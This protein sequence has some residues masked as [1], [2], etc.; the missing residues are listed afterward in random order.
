MSFIK[1]IILCVI[2]FCAISIP[3]V[4]AQT[5][6]SFHHLTRNEGLLHDNVTCM[7]QDEI[8]YIWIGTHRGINR[9]D[10]YAMDSYQ[11]K[12]NKSM[13]V[14]AN[15]VYD[16]LNMGKYLWLATQEG[17]F[18]FNIHTKQYTSFK[19]ADSALSDFFKGVRHLKRAP[20]NNCFW[21]ISNQQVR[22]VKITT[23]SE[24]NT[25]PLLTSVRIGSS[26]GLVSNNGTPNVVDNGKD[27]GWL[28]ANNT[29]STYIIHPNHQLDILNNVPQISCIGLRDMAY[30]KGYL[31]LAYPEKL[32]KYKVGKLGKLTLLKEKIFKTHGGFIR[33]KPAGKYIWLAAND[34]LIRINKDNLDRFQSYKHA[35]NVDNSV[36]NDINNIYID[37]NDNIWVSGWMAGIAYAHT[38]QPFFHTLKYD[39]FNTSGAVGGNAEFISALHYD[40]DGYVYI[41]RKFGGISRL[42]TKTKQIEWDYSINAAL[43]NSITFIET[44]NKSIY[45]AINNN[46]IIINKDNRSIT[47]MLPMANNGYIFGLAFDRLHRL[48]AA[49]YAG[50]ECFENIAG[51][52]VSKY[53]LTTHSPSPRR[54]S[55]NFLHNIYSEK[56]SNELI[57]TSTH[58]INRVILDAK[59]GI[60]NVLVY[61]TN[62][63][64]Q[65]LSSNFVWSIDKGGPNTYWVGT[66]GSGLN[67]ITFLDGTASPNAYKAEQ[68]GMQEGAISN[69]IEAIELDKFGRVWCSGFNLSYF[70]D[71]IKRFRVFRAEDGLQGT[72]FATSSSTKDRNGTIYFGGSQGLNYFL[73][74]NEEFKSSSKDIYFTRWS[75]NGEII[76]SDI[77]Y[78]KSIELLYPNNYF[79]LNF[80]TLDFENAQ[81][82]RFRY[83]IKDYDN[84]HIIEEGSTPVISYQKLPYGHYKLLVEAGDWQDWSGKVYELDIYSK[85]PFWLS[86]WA[87]ISYTILALTLVYLGIKYFIQWT[88]MKHFF[89]IRKE[90]ERQHKEMLQMKTRFFM[91]V[92]H[93]FR[94][95]LT[96][97]NH[98][99]HE[100]KEDETDI[101]H[102]YFDT[103]IRNTRL[104]SNMI[105]KLLDFHKADMKALKL[106]VATVD[107]T[108]FFTAIYDEFCIWAR[109][110]N[111]GMQLHIVQEHI[112]TL[113]DE[114][115]ASKIISNIL[116]NS[117]HHCHPEGSIDID[118]LTGTYESVLPLH[119]DYIEYTDKLAQGNQLII[120]I[121]DTGEGIA[122]KDLP[123]V[124]DRLHQ[125]GNH[126]KQYASSGIGLSLVKSLIGLHHGGIIMSSS[127]G[128]GTETILFFPMDKQAYEPSE[129][130]PVSTFQIQEYLSN[131][132]F[133]QPS[134]MKD[135]KETINQQD[136]DV[137]LL[138]ED[139]EEVLM[140][141]KEYLYK[142]YNIETATNGKEALEKCRIAL[143]DLIISDVMMP[144]MDGF[145]L[146]RTLKE[147]L[148]TCHIPIIL[149]TAVAQEEKQ[150]EGLEI[151]ADAYIAKPY[152]PRL[153]KINVQN[154]IAKSRL[155]RT[156]SQLGESIREKIKNNKDKEMFDEFNK[157]ILQNLRTV[158]FSIGHVVNSLG[159]NRTAL[160]SFIKSNTGM[161]L[162][163]YI[164]KLRLDK[165][166]ELIGNTDL[167]ISEVALSVGI[168]SLSYFTR[169]FK[170]QFGLTP[171]EFLKSKS[172]NK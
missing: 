93:E 122:K 48:W 130:S 24:I 1:Q 65:S 18:C 129:L 27:I 70:D 3:K 12:Q 97:I 116:S 34:Q 103:I 21:L 167:T 56:N 128:L 64:V 29:L 46:I 63:S 38:Y 80:S 157:I 28:A 53:T 62:N 17:L 110:A 132:S 108:D 171:S 33:I 90:K 100:L 73:P 101:P 109:S 124:F 8:G 145:E 143:P 147:S 153:L 106:H 59:G 77:E 163:K 161:S 36:L 94:T 49:T 69:D 114:E 155:I 44:D 67:K 61:T 107:V 149:L 76:D 2:G 25:T 95:P 51:K 30:D 13:A 6:L 117:L 99:V 41:G 172:N 57:V 104:L 148:H 75:A 142:Y 164:M 31:W 66:M 162:G 170:E 78:S 50:L 158:D 42:N 115:Q 35:S 133:L 4:I 131:Y 45:A 20:A 154:L 127:L 26:K 15:R 159:T 54:L 138:V 82:T 96:L 169:S 58:G 32:A 150:I 84:W 105:D 23:G 91:D 152:N 68:F 136:K 166:A 88:K 7:I 60:E 168:D 121:S 123:L 156:S 83:K 85:P 86:W 111:V 146:C 144:E 5:N 14:T 11:Y 134:K 89:S 151:G 141:L 140:I 125:A 118:I 120:K 98:A 72:T 39:R 74:R 139:N 81:H 79:S 92:S 55:S 112:E 43:L 22:L 47:Q 40:K 113:L 37:R 87:Y 71:Q 160:Y 165:A 10:G 102:Q 137:L 16:M 135:D 126:H 119:K 52:W 9:Y 19:A